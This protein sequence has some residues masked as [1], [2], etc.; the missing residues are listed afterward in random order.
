MKNFK[1]FLVNMGFFCLAFVILNASGSSAIRADIA[2]NNSRTDANLSAW[3]AYWDMDDGVSELGKTG[4]TY[5]EISYFE[6]FFNAK[7]ELIVPKDLFE[8]KEQIEAEK[9]F[10]VRYLTVVNDVQTEEKTSFKDIDVVKDVLADKKAQ[11]KHA[12][13]IIELAKE[14]NC[15]GI[16]LDYERVF[17]DKEASELYL[18]FI[19]IL[20]DKTSEQDMKLRVILE[21]NVNF[22][23]YKFPEGPLY[24]VMLY[25][26]Y[27]THSEKP[28]PKADFMFIRN[29]INKMKSLPKPMGVA[30]ATGGCYWTDKGDRKFISSEEAVELARK[31]KKTP[32]RSFTSNAL[33]FSYKEKGVEYTVWYADK[34]TLASWINR[35]E[36]EG[37]NDIC[38]WRLGGNEKIYDF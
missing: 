26:L 20:Y 24:M 38:I 16:D 4:N 30:L 13:E 34:L 35:A 37:I 27:G 1:R 33:S 6:A 28:G 14:N 2:G 5:N 8:D 17:R 11:E 12:D 23:E 32:K 22:Q 18:E 15:N 7:E 36:D 29:T 31:Y 9:N 10:S 25:N 21:P 3:L 19:K